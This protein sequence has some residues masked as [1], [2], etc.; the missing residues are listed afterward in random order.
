MDTTDS[1]SEQGEEENSR[2]NY[3]EIGNTMK[4]V[5]RR[6]GG[7]IIVKTTNILYNFGGKYIPPGQYVFPFSYKTGE[8]FP[9]SFQVKIE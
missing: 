7:R 3:V 9:A 6:K 1:S 2:Y 8:N 5:N 4:K